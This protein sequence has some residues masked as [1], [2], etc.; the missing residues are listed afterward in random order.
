MPTAS[1]RSSSSTLR[2]VRGRNEVMVVMRKGWCWGGPRGPSGRVRRGGGGGTTSTGGGSG[3]VDDVDGV[4]LGGVGA[5]D[6]D[7][8]EGTVTAEPQGRP[9]AFCVRQATAAVRRSV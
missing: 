3:G 5:R 1:S 9:L 8:R 7:A 4:E 2:R 6:G